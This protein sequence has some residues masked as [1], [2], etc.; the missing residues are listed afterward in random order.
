MARIAAA[1]SSAALRRLARSAMRCFSS[2]TTSAALITRRRAWAVRRGRR[3]GDRRG[4]CSGRRQ[5]AGAPAPIAWHRGRP[6]WAPAWPAAAAALACASAAAPSRLRPQPSRASRRH[7]ALRRLRGRALPALRAGGAS[8]RVLLPAGAAA[9]P[10]RGFVLAALQL[11]VV[12]TARFAGLFR[13]PLRSSRLTKV[14]FLRT[15]TWMVRALPLAS[16]CLISLVDL[17]VSVIFL[18][19]P[20]PAVPCELRRKSSRRSLSDSVSAS[21]R[22]LGDAGRLQLLEQRAAAGG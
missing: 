9:R 3:C 1:S 4:G 8:R 13:P 2:A 7:G 17:R 19:S 15:S 16:A 6:P 5:H 11:G 22:R 12:D 14:R 10:G 18:R 21:F 20:P